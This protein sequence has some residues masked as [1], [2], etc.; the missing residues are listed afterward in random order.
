MDRPADDAL[1]RD[2]AAGRDEAF[3]RLYDL[4]GLRLLRTARSICGSQEDAEDALQEVFVGLVRTG[5]A[6]AEVKNMNA[7]LFSSIRRA[8]LRRIAQRGHEQPAAQATFDTPA[9]GAS[10]EPS[11][12]LSRALDSLPTEQREVVA[13]KV[14]GGLT[15][16][17]IAGMLDI[18]INTAA[19]RYRYALE[20]LRAAFEPRTGA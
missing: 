5:P 3:A 4:F 11:D 12:R 14:D 7:Y 9:R 18:S 20:K 6:L 10:A 17:E 2:L 19:S 1:L 13:L 16:D 15:F 8:A